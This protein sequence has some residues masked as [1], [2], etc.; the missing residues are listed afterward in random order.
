M[1]ELQIGEV[2]E[3]CKILLE[4]RI[5]KN[6]NC[7]DCYFYVG[8]GVCDDALNPIVHCS[9]HFRTDNNDVIF[10]KVGEAQNA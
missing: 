8:E 2:F 5:N 1:K 10:V 3:H 6:G 4:C 9:K 7:G